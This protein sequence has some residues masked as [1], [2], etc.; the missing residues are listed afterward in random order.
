M[1]SL[2]KLAAAKPETPPGSPLDEEQADCDR[3]IQALTA[4]IAKLECEKLRGEWNAA[5]DES[6]VACPSLFSA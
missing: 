3:K 2:Q 5:H 6:A 4:Q 1:I